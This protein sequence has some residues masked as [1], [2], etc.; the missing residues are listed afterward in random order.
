MVIEGPVPPM[1]P[2]PHPHLAAFLAWFG[3]PRPVT[4]K[5]KNTRP[6]QPRPLGT[7]PYGPR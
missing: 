3:K 5:R 7:P 2:S 6:A 1:E 4:P